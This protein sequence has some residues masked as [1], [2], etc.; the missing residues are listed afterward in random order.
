MNTKDGTIQT[1]LVTSDLSAEA[2]CAFRVAAKLQTAFNAK[3]Q[4]LAVIEDVDQAAMIFALQNK[5][6]PERDV[7]TQLT[8]HIE[9]QLADQ[10]KQHLSFGSWEQKVIVGK[11]HVH[12]EIMNYADNIK[13]DL[14]VMARHGRRGIVKFVTGSTTDKVVRSSTAPVVV[15]PV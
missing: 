10:S 13:A 3:V 11:Q 1:I 6:E 12:L 15:V 4:V 2:S 7:K 8:E 5:I 14:I 9:K